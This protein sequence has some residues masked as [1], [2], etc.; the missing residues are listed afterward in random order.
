[1]GCLGVYGLWLHWFLAR[2]ALALSRF[3]AGVLVFLVSLGTAVVVMGPGL[4]VN[5]VG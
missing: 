4:L 5:D 2:N 1:M 3:R